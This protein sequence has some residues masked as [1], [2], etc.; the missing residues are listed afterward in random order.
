MPIDCSAPGLAIKLTPRER[1]GLVQRRLGDWLTSRS[2]RRRRHG[3]R[4]SIRA[5][6]RGCREMSWRA[7]RSPAGGAAS[8]PH[9]AEPFVSLRTSHL[10]L[11][12]SNITSAFVNLTGVTRAP[13]ELR[14][15][16]W[17]QRARGP[18]DGHAAFRQINAGEHRTAFHGQAAWTYQDP[19]RDRGMRVFGGFTA[20]RRTNTLIPPGFV[21]VER[22]SDGPIP[23]LLDPGPGTDR[24]WTAGA[25]LNA[26]FA[27]G[28]GR[29]RASGG[30]RSSPD[31]KRQ[32]R[33]PARK[34]RSPA[35][36]GS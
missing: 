8:S 10:E 23:N 18:V 26:G 14:V 13:G 6:T 17:L 20:R 12:D 15:I 32:A 9:R 30:T 29:R 16:G 33:R 5:G 22:L 28:A 7:G 31:S 36:W 25:R 35:S 11:I 3:R 4:P 1:K 21:A 27:P 24:T 19:N 2:Q 34:A